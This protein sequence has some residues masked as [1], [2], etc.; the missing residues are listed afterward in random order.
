MVTARILL[1]LSFDQGII[2]IHTGDDDSGVNGGFY[3]DRN[4]GEGEVK[5]MINL[6]HPELPRSC[7]SSWKISKA[8]ISGNLLFGANLENIRLGG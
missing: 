2:R 6:I 1:Y 5:L 4:N 7:G 3:W 8:A